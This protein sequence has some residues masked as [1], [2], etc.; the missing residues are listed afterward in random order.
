MSL[1]HR[2]KHERCVAAVR[3]AL[4]R[5]YAAESTLDSMRP[6]QIAYIKHLRRSGR[7]T[8][9]DAVRKAQRNRP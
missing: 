5:V 3:K 1:G 7:I 9:A 4:L 8:L 2:R 6:D